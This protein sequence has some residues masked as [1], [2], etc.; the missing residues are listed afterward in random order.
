MFTRARLKNMKIWKEQLWGEGLRLAP[1]TLLL[2]PNSAGKSSVLQSLLLAKQTFENPDRHLDLNLGGRA[3]DII[4]LGTYES[5]IHGRDT[6]LE[7]GIGFCVHHVDSE[8]RPPHA[9]YSATYRVLHSRPVLREL[10]I[11][12]DGFECSATRGERGAY[13]LRATG[14]RP[15]PGAAALDSKRLFQP[16]RSIALPHTAIAELGAA[17]DRAQD[18]SLAIRSAAERIRY[19]G[20]LRERPQRSY[21]WTGIDSDEIGKNGEYAAHVLIAGVN[22]RSGRA[23]NDGLVEGVSHWLRQM[24][25]ADALQ[26]RQL[27]RSRHYEIEVVQGRNA[28]NIIDVGF[29][30]SQVLPMI[31]LALLADPGTVVVAEEPEIHLHPR[32]QTILAELLTTVARERGIQ[33]LV[34][35]HSEHLFRRLQTLVAEGAHGPEQCALY[36][37]DKDQTGEPVA[38]P[39]EMNEVGRIDNW[40][41]GFFGDTVGETKRQVMGALMRAKVTRKADAE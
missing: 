39:L 38:T 22:S 26:V 33:F 9:A 3:T 20:P 2:G 37:F 11:S 12:T 36:F 30:I 16:E 28:A 10:V 31:V 41:D 19:L 40:P 23:N 5:L 6:K 21:L 7:M 32:A 18:L 17:G 24:G 25:V 8:L 13:R 29:G 15:R 14:Y 35:T 27:G 34:E 1:V 4:D